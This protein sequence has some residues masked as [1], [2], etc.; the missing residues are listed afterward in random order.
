MKVE[1][2][3][4]TK[5]IQR[6]FSLNK[7]SGQL[8]LKDHEV[9]IM[10]C[11]YK[12]NKYRTSLLTTFH[13]GFAFL[14]SESPDDYAWVLQHIKSVYGSLGLEDPDVIVTDRGLAL[15]EAIEEVFL[16]TINGGDGIGGRKVRESR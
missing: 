15:T 2:K 1:L 12:T 6:L 9:L 7:K 16:K 13:A 8:L 4:D 3:K 10:D 11:I 14:S 5:E